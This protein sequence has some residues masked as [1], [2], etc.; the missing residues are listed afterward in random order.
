MRIFPAIQ[1]TVGTWRYYSTKMTAAELALQVKF[2]SEVWESKALDHWIQRALNHSRAKKDISGYLARHEDRFFNSIVV[3]AIEGNPKFF[4]VSITDDPRFQL[5]D[6]DRMNN[7]FGILRFDGNEKYYALDGQHRLRAIRALIDKE[8]EYVAPKGFEDEEFS[9]IIV[10][11]KSD[12]SRDEFMRKYRRLFSHLNRHA[13]PMDKATTIIMEEDDAFA[14]CTRRLIQDHPFFS[15]I[16]GE[17]TRVRCEGGENMSVHESYYTNIITLYEMTITLLS[18]PAR[19]NSEGWGERGKRFKV[20]RPSDETLDALYEELVMYWNA[21][22]CEFAVLYNEPRLMRTNL[23]EEHETDGELS[24]NH[25]LFRPIGQDLLSR[26]IR[27]KLD[28]QLPDPSNFTESDLTAV[29]SGLAK[30]EWRLFCSPWKNL[31]F[32]YQEEDRWKMRSEDRKP[33]ENL[34]L[35]LLQWIVGVDN[36][37]TEEDLENALKKQWRALL[38][39]VNDDE[40]EE[41]WNQIEEQAASFRS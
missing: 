32:V 28:K 8:T 2:A 37:G 17:T 1:G 34:G 35:R 9:V 14:I 36:Y 16:D 6:T 15:W 13:K 23:P 22:L 38:V 27:S 7:S 26:L 3:A 30:V 4:P 12:E 40:A 31:L 10:V 20:I 41:L 24:T 11:Q 18:T 19:C 29:V 21:I 33:A 25:L 39:N 5:I